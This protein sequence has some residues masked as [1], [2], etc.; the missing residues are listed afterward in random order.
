MRARVFPRAFHRVRFRFHV[1]VCVCTCL[2]TCM[3][4]RARAPAGMRGAKL[5]YETGAEIVENAVS[6]V[7]GSRPILFS[8]SP[9]LPAGLRLDPSTGDISGAPAAVC[10]AAM[11]MITAKND[12]GEVVTPL[13]LQVA[14][15]EE[16]CVCG[17]TRCTL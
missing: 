7:T 11:Y 3:C 15:A 8:A 4:A 16:V 14:K 17:L 9:A 2:C 5:V 12:V 1:C 10:E 6:S 13:L